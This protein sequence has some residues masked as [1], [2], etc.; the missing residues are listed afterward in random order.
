MRDGYTDLYT[1]ILD[2]THFYAQNF[3]LYK[4]YYG[5]EGRNQ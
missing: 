5:G 1:I 4:F 3:F 2:F